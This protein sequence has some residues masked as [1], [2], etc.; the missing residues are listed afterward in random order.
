MFPQHPKAA[1]G[2]TE[3]EVPHLGKVAAAI[4]FDCL[5]VLVGFEDLIEFIAVRVGDEPSLALICNR[6][7]VQ[8]EDR[9]SIL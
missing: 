4:T 1:I 5:E 8:D 7:P 9:L 3:V 6:F 2:A